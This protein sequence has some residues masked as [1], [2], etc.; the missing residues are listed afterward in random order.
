MKKIISLLMALIFVFSMATPS[1]AAVAANE[2]AVQ[3][4]VAYD[5]EGIAGANN[6][7]GKVVEIVN[8]IWTRIVDFFKSIFGFGFKPGTYNV[9]YYTDETKSVIYDVVPTLE[10]DEIAPI[11]IPTRVGHTFKSWQPALPKTMPDEDVEVYATWSIKTVT[12][13]FVTG[14]ESIKVP[15][16]KV[17]YGSVINL[18]TVDEVDNQILYAWETPAGDLIS[19]PGGTLKV[20]DDTILTAK[21]RVKDTTIT[22]DPNGGYW[23]ENPSQTASFKITQPAG[24]KV[25]ALNIYL[26]HKLCSSC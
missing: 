20:S 5:D 21:W 8:S 9:I 23:N 4:S 11:A 7:L 14:F 15:D 2:A 12:V 1:F 13:K 16:V 10:G 6:L 24:S 26:R 3:S 18:P 19:M 22:F 17:T 25:T